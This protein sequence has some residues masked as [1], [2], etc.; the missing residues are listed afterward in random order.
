MSSMRCLRRSGESARSGH[1]D[2]YVKMTKMTTYFARWA[3][4]GVTIRF[5]Q[6]DLLTVFCLTAKAPAT[7]RTS[8]QA[9]REF[10]RPSHKGLKQHLRTPFYVRP[11]CL[12]YHI[13]ALFGVEDHKRHFGLTH[14]FLQTS[15]NP[16]HHGTAQ[17]RPWL[18]GENIPRSWHQARCCRRHFLLYR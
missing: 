15:M 16:G 11:G 1:E 10:G 13:S 6:M 17:I 14:G 8:T 9:G 2:W 4:H 5:P 18:P 3:C 12:L 7:R